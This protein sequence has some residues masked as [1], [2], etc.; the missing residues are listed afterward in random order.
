[1]VILTVNV[2]RN[3]PTQRQI[4]EN[5]IANHWETRY[6]RPVIRQMDTG[7]LLLSGQSA[8]L[9]N[10]GQNAPNVAALDHLAVSTYGVK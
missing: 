1:V 10:V 7:F 4:N 5:L 8:L 6:P 9:F 3:K 2:V